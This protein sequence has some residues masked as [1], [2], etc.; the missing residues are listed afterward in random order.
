MAKQDGFS[1]ETMKSMMQVFD[2]N[3]IDRNAVAYHSMLTPKEAEIAGL[4]MKREEVE[5]MKRGG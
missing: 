4:T 5:E 3:H 1:N 2:E